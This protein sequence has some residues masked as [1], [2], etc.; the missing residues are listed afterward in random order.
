MEK[1]KA[2]NKKYL[3]GL[4]TAL[5]V[6]GFCSESLFAKRYPTYEYI[7]SLSFKKA[8]EYFFTAEEST[9]VL[10][11]ANVSP[12]NV[13]VYVNALPSNVSFISSKKEILLPQPGSDDDNGTRV[14]MNLKFA[15]PGSYKVNAI[16]VMVNGIYYR[17]PFERV[18]VLD[19]P[20]Q[21]MPELSVKF[22]DGRKPSSKGIIA[23][24]VGDKIKFTLYSK[25]AVS[26]ENISW[27][28]PENSLFKEVKSFDFITS[29]SENK[30]FSPEEIPLITYEWQPLVKGTYDFP[31]INISAI[32]YN[33]SRVE[34]TPSNLKMNVLESKEALPSSESEYTAAYAYA[35][36]EFKG[37]EEKTF[38]CDD[39]AV[40]KICSLRSKERHS[41]PLFSKA[42]K[43]R[44]AY[45]EYCGLDNVESEES[46]PYAIILWSL[47][48]LLILI[49]I[50]LF[51][52]KFK[53][54]AIV[55]IVTA[56]LVFIYSVIYSKNLSQKRG[57]FKGGLLSPIPEKNL[58]TAVE[59]PAGCLVYIEEKASDWLYVRHN[60]SYGWILEDSV[61][62]IK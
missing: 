10:D 55:F 42:L 54:Q 23:S 37:K 49:S 19:N 38:V 27:Q 41:L 9:Y 11:I 31:K 4:L 56:G 39:A 14:I 60:E 20:R 24:R 43:E 28:V 33:G 5:F 12:D 17:I 30:T 21:L 48:A 46:L 40:K 36:D 15:R 47:F 52:F 44:M 18:Q 25:Y 35:F 62:L 8:D 26:I 3:L 34:L 13:L 51:V 58:S 1:S 50:L 6:W 7:R 45:E 2:K 29:S 32:S 53:I 57:V 61:Y 22:E 59:L 16:D